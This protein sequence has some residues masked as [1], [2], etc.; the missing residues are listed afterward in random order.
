[1]LWASAMVAALLVAGILL[2]LPRLQP[3]TGTLLVVGASRSAETI[4]PMTF[5]LHGTS[6]WS[7]VGSVSGAVPAAP[8][9]RE[10]L[11]VQVAVGGYD[12]I[13]VGADQQPVPI[14]V[15]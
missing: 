6:G 10:L 2:A 4:A 1:M 8:E 5:S 14:S 13:R 12:A 11:A 9:Q 7:A 3:Q 15:V